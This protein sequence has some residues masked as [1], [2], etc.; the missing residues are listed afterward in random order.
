MRM[1]GTESVEYHRATVLGRGDDYPGMALEYY[2]SRGETPLV[3]GGAGREGLSLEGAVTPENYEAVFGPGGARDPRTGDRLASTRRPGM[4]VVISAHKSVAELGVIG[5]A[6]DMHRIMDAER[7]GT[8]AYLDGVTRQMGG[9][10]GEAASA[11]ATGGLIYAHTRHATSRAGDPCPH[12]HVL[13]ANLVEMKDEKGGWKAADTA[14]WREHLHAATMAG[15]VAAARVAVELGYAIEP[16]PGPSGR[17]GHWKIAGVPD[18][19]MELHSKRAAEIEAE[20]QRRGEGSYRARGVAARATRKAKQSRAGGSLMERWRAEIASVGWPAE[21][22]A[23]AVDAARRLRED[24]PRSA[25]KTLG[26]SSPTR[27]QTTENWP[28]ARFFPAATSSWRWPRTCSASPPRCS[29]GWSTGPWPTPRWCPW[30][31][32]P[33]PAKRCTRS[34]LSWPGRPPS[35]RAWP[36]SWPAPTPPPYRATVGEAIEKTEQDI[37]AALSARA[38][39]GGRRHLHFGPRGRAGRGRGRGRQDHH[40]AGRGRRFRA[41]GRRSY[42]HRHLWPSRPQ[43]RPRGRDRQSRTLASL[44]W[45]LDHG[46]MA[47]TEKSVVILDEVGMTDDAD[48]ARLATY[49]ELAGAK[50]VLTG[51]H[52]QLGPVG[53]GGALAALVKRH[54]DAVHYLGENRRQHDPG[55]RQALESLRDGDVAEAVSWYVGHGRVHAVPTRD[56]AFQA[57]VEAWAADVAAGHETGLYAWRRA[58]VAELN[59]RARAW[60]EASGRLTGPELACPSGAT[61]KSGDRVVTL[62]P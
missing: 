3:W 49:T 38:T 1:M 27:W 26:R 42:R 31:A 29:T 33:V 45:R 30:S 19:V 24:P 11:S 57:T 37:G 32:W 59:R 7:D 21:R 61:Y 58:N 35:P 23:A 53:P 46:Q 12:D 22:L 52:R 9:R 54:P 15:R 44:I 25:S 14:L 39:G 43:P 20:C 62:A 50:L 56:E 60:M 16:D 6:E 34:P 47:L 51:D 13:L 28:G 2:A 10:R 17:L 18:E 8:L 55:E 48:L 4:E 5:R 41:S 40:A 36:T